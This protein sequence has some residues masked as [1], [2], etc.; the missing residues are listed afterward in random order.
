M[1]SSPFLRELVARVPPP[2]EP[3]FGKATWQQV[4]AELGTA[5]PADYVEFIN[6]YGSCEFGYYLGIGDPRDYQPLSYHQAWCESGD[7]YREMRE[8]FPEF[9]PLAAWPEAGGFL[10]WGTDID[11]NWFGWLT[12]GEPDHWPIAVW[13]RQL[14][15]GLITH[16]SMT[17]FLTGWL[18]SPPAY[19]GFPDLSDEDDRDDDSPSEITC[20]AWLRLRA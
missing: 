11:G 20:T 19:Q 16:V 6:T 10:G 3:S 7:E 15:D 13:G 5:M 1:T 4:F 12:E 14:E 2:P 17:E 18:S 9:H 8:E